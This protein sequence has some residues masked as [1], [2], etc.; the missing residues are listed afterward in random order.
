[1]TARNPWL[2]RLKVG[3]LAPK[4][5]WSL[6]AYNPRVRYYTSLHW[7]TH[8]PNGLAQTIVNAAALALEPGT[9]GIACRSPNWVSLYSA[10]LEEQDLGAMD[11]FALALPPASGVGFMVDDDE[12][13][14]VVVYSGGRRVA[15]H[16][17]GEGAQDA[18][19]L[20]GEVCGPINDL[21]GALG[22]D[23]GAVT[24]AVTGG[25]ASARVAALAALTGIPQDLAMVGFD[26]L[27][28]LEEDGELPADF[29]F[30]ESLLDEAQ[31]SLGTFFGQ[32]DFEEPDGVGADEES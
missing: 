29:E 13:L 17:S 6:R 18:F 11:A 10:R 23:A 30:L 27:V 25:Q 19:S 12:S 1:M 31:P 4:G 28:D 24:A 3:L 8:E 20:H 2:P 21:A 32:P 14:A 5:S 26:D 16:L 9:E 7:R 15:L 22:L